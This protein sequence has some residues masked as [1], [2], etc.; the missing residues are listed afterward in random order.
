MHRKSIGIVGAVVIAKQRDI[1]DARLPG[2]V[3]VR[4]MLSLKFY[5]L[6]QQ[7]VKSTWWEHDTG[8]Q[9][10]LQTI[11]QPCAW[12]DVLSFPASTFIQLLVVRT[13][14][15]AWQLVYTRCVVLQWSQ[16]IAQDMQSINR[17]WVVEIFKVLLLQQQELH[18]N[19]IGVLRGELELISFDDRLQFLEIVVSLVP[20]ST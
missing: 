6:S 8:R 17:S 18:L 4:A 1:I 2:H 10:R 13:H 16:L 3:V 14:H 5:S 15:V 19:E 9:K 20:I 7:R 12:P 11:H